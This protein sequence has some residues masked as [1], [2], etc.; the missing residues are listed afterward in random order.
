MSKTITLPDFSGFQRIGVDTETT[1]LSAKDVPVGASFYTPDKKKYYLRWGH[2]EGGNNCTLVQFVRWARTQFKNPNK[3]YVFHN[4]V[5]D[6]RMLAAVGVNMVGKFHDSAVMAALLNEYEPDFSL[7]GLGT[8]YLGRTK[9]DQALNEYCAKRFGGKATRDAQAGNY[10]RASGDVVEEYAQDDP[11]LCFLLAEFFQPQIESLKLTE[12]YDIECNVIP[13]L[14]KMFQ[15]GVK[16]DIKKAKETKVELLDEFETMNK[17]WGR[18]YGV[19]YTVKKDL[20]ALFD[21]EGIPYPRTKIGNPSITKDVLEALEHPIGDHLRGMRQMKHYSGTFIENYLLKNADGNGVIHPQF[22]Q[23]K[24][25][26]GGTITGRFSS[27]GGLNAQNIPARDERWAPVIRGLFVPWTEDHQWMKC[28]YSQIEYRFFAHYAEGQLLQAYIDDPYIDFHDMVAA[29]TGLKRKDA[30]NINFGILY[31]MGVA[32]TALKLGVSLAV[33]K[34]LLQAYNK[35]VP[36]AKALYTA[37][38]NRAN[39]RGYIRTWGGRISRFQRVPGKRAFMGTHKALNKLLQGSAA[40][41]IK[42]AMI[43]VAPAL[44]WEDN[45][46]HLTVHD[47]LD[48]S[49]LKGDAGLRFARDIKSIMQDFDVSVP[50]ICEPEFGPDWGHTEKVDLAA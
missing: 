17:E 29:M 9:S 35:R 3:E 10:W 41:M 2:E 50:I 32:K 26:F 44:D 47:E 20:V 4:A 46:M 36:E 21:K 8:K 39:K 14:V 7:G 28:D 6:L 42:K 30:K 11:E 33:A 19:D 43:A 22:H 13:V 40:D 18:I 24:S 12:V 16:I 23:V 15:A 31:G 25:S 38:M 49:T 34:K 1:G 48:F 5:F 37:A 27:S 45:I